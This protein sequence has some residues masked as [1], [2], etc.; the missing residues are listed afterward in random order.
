MNQSVK[1]GTVQCA[2]KGLALSVAPVIYGF[3]LFTLGTSIIELGAFAVVSSLAA[4]IW[5]RK[6]SVKNQKAG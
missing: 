2:R 5:S 6:A 1:I 4:I 3:I